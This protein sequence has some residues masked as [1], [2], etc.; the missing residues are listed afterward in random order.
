MP[1]FSVTLD[2]GHPEQAPH[3]LRYIY[4][5]IYI[6]KP[7]D[8]VPSRGWRL[9]RMCHFQAFSTAC[10]CQAFAKHGPKPCQ[11]TPKPGQAF[12]QPSPAQPRITT[13]PSPAQPKPWCGPCQSSAR[14]FPGF[15]WAVFGPRWR[16][17]CPILGRFRAP[18]G[19]VSPF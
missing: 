13:Q 5:F 1:M 2:L 9:R 11:A 6:G 17:F 18:C 10:H 3:L 7:A 16:R 14:A 8:P 15:R 4:L 19:C 12:A